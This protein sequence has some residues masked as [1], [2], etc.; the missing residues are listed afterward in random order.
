MKKILEFFADRHVL[1]TLFTISIIML[2][3]NSARTLKRDLLPEVDF[4][5]AIITTL[6]PGASPE[7]VELNVTHK[8]EDE[9]KAVTGIKRIASTSME[10]LSVITVTIDLDVK[11]MDQVK[12]DIRQ[13]VDRVTDFPPEVTESPLI[14][15]INTSLIP[16]IEVGIAGDLPYSELREL[17]GRLEERL[18]E[19]PGVTR[20]QKYGYRAR[21]IKVEVDPGAIERYQ[22]PLR[23]I[24]QA[25][26]ARNIRLTGGTF[27]SYTSEKNVVTLAQFKYPVEVGDVIVRSTFEGPLI[28]VKD[29]AVVKDD[30]EDEMILSRMQGQE[31]ISFLVYKTE[32]ADII[33][34][35]RAIKRM[36]GEAS[37]RAEGSVDASTERTPE[38]RG[39][40]LKAAKGLIRGERTSLE[41]Y[42]YGAAQVLFSQD[43]SRYVQDRFQIVLT[44]GAIGLV[45]VVL[46]LTVFLNLRT[47]FWVAMGIPVSIMGA[48][49]LLPLFGGFLDNISMFS[50]ILVIG[51]IVD[52]GIII[53]ESIA[54]RRSVGD[55]PLN[56]AINGTHA[57]FLPVLTTVLTTF[58]AFAPMFFQTGVFGRFVFVIPL[59]VSLAL[60]VS[61]GEAL[62]ALP[63]H[64]KRGME[65]SYR[66]AQ[67][68]AVREWFNGLRRVYRKFA[69]RFLKF[70]YPLLG[71]FIGV[72]VGTLWYAKHNMDFILFPSKGADRFVI[73][74]ELPTGTPLQ[75]TSR[76]IMEIEDLLQA[77]PEAELET[78]VTRVGILMMTSGQAEHYGYIAVDL[79]PYEER[80]RTADEIIEALREKTDPLE[81]FDKI[82]FLVVAGGPPVGKPITL[83]L[84]GDDDAM[85]KALADEVVA[86]LG[87]MDGVK[88]IDRDDKPGKQQIEIK[89]DYDKLSRLGLTVADVAQN[90]RIAYDGEVVTS[91]R[92]GDEDVEFR[93]QLTEGARRDVGVLRNMLVPNQRG[94]LIRLKEA[95]RLETGPGP[96]A[97][98]HFD[99]KRTTTIVADVD[100]ELTTPIAATRALLDH[101]DLETDWPGMRIR[102]GG[103]AEESQESIRS[104]F[105]TMFVAFIGIYFLLILLFN[106]FTQPFLVMIAVPFGIVG[107]ILALALHGEPLSFIAM[108]GTIGL[109]GVVVNDSLVLVSYL[110]ELR[111]QRPDQNIR[112]VVALGTAS[113]LRAIVLTTL[114]TVAG[115]LPLAYGIGGTDL[116]LSPMALALGYG[117]LFATPLTLVLVPCLYVIGYDMGRIFGRSGKRTTKGTSSEGESNG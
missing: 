30:F 12:D 74:V 112:E 55:A 13:A 113:R 75:T 40:L 9:L 87:T 18:E 89:I 73:E 104:L 33:R 35:V 49:F 66:G 77:L 5:E 21:E 58:L 81:G 61:M 98:R 27:E 44:N 14:E 102:V 91:I 79:T 94:R 2:G 100:Q 16:I 7:D 88:D 25:V 47:A 110:N 97:L 67:R 6:Y 36:I 8:I 17:A 23:E 116:F 92:E 86:Y 39:G 26:R 78:F 48:V 51:I 115:L 109:A 54:Y 107:V 68:A 1:A 42:Q 32:A 70:R 95:A 93:V 80:T 108:I 72:F 28:K 111:K 24:V 37:V 105:A 57:I 34:T 101:F 84:I 10:N 43:R 52:D 19:I 63:A 85:R 117:L 82:T 45:L 29:L 50:L 38:D 69:Y 60:F 20:V 4:G 103:E 31:A 114:T 62:L 22:I 71:V 99:G 11:D 53:S 59:T 65:R 3:L 15:E 76:K 41:P 46:M 56:A 106:S 64:L 83:R 96:N 90:A